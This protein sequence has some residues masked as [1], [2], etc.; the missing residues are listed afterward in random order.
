MTDRFQ[1]R[2]WPPGVPPDV[3]QLAVVDTAHGE[4]IVQTYHDRK[5]LARGGALA[6]AQADAGRWNAHPPVLTPIFHPRPLRQIRLPDGQ[7]VLRQLPEP[8]P[9]AGD[10]AYDL[11]NRT[12]LYRDFAYVG[13]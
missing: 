7:A 13:T 1:V 2:K 4:R 5:D 12:S 9:R 10:L 11:T 3:G 6:A 8:L